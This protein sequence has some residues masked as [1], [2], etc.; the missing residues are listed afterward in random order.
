MQTITI[1]AEFQVKHTP[2][3]EAH[4]RQV[5]NSYLKSKGVNVGDDGII[6]V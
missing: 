5:I 1:T 3:N 6:R 4:L 2:D